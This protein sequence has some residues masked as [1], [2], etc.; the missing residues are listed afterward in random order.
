MKSVVGK[1]LQGRY[2]I[3]QELRRED[4]YTS[5]LAEDKNSSTHSNYE[6]QRLH[7]QQGNQI[8]SLR[9]WQNLQKRFLAEAVILEKLGQHPQIPQL[10]AYFIDGREFFLV[11]ELISGQTL[12]ELTAK[13]YLSEEQGVIWLQD[14]LNILNF[15]HGM[16]VMHLNINPHN[17]I[18]QQEDKH[19]F[20][21]NFAAIEK[22][23]FNSKK[24]TN[25]ISQRS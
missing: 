25:H 14:I 8:L 13:E 19:L 16:G 22:F 10:Q 2:L 11:K 1:L 7:P 24:P 20:L 3:T 9:T 4:F 17:L 18:L 5:Y 21:T 23:N 15:A 12:V 6:V